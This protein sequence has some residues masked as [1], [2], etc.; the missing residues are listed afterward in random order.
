MTKRRPI[1]LAVLAVMVALA[2]GIG[3]FRFEVNPASV[4]GPLEKAL[5]R[6][7]GYRVAALGGAAFTAFPWPVL[8]LSGLELVKGGASAETASIPL[9][10]ARINV[11]SWLAGDPRISALA[12]FEP[13]ISLVSAENMEE[14]EAVGAV[15][16]NFLRQDRRP[17]LTQLR[18][19]SGEVS[20]DG[21]RWLAGLAIN[22]S[23]VAGNDVRLDAAGD[24]RG[25]PLRLDAVVSPAPV[26][27]FRPIIWKLSVGDLN[28]AFTGM[29]TSPPALEADGQL[30]VT[31]GAGALRSRP[32][33]LSRA[34]TDMLDGLTI[35]GSGRIALPAVQLRQAVIRRGTHSFTGGL[36][37]N[38]M[39]AQPRIAATLHAETLDLTDAMGTFLEGDP[40]ES[41]LA[42]LSG[43]A[44]LQAAAVDMRLS[45]A[46]LDIGALRLENAALSVKFGGSR[47]EA[48]LSHADISGGS[49]KARLSAAIV[50]PELELKCTG[51]VEQVDLGAVLRRAGSAAL[52]GILTGHWTVDATGQRAEDLVRNAGGRA[53]VALRNGE[54]VGLDVERFLRRTEL[55]AAPLPDGRSRFQQVDMGFALKSGVATLID[56]HVKGPQ[57]LAKVQGSASIAARSLDILARLSFEGAGTAQPREERAIRI[58]GPWARPEATPAGIPASGRS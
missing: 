29:L 5:S 9:V 38:L 31:L 41:W 43:S 46:R 27:A 40:V 1:L 58:F 23:N 33:S 19:Q 48:T 37:M 53:L 55:P 15:I 35:A 28:A 34:T 16:R 39:P 25:Q 13:K 44:P 10:K 8:Q 54:G 24:Y 36:D 2:V 26:A 45:V 18:V 14:T 17:A 4:R 32:L 3:S 49:A 12:L 6:D 21:G 42:A 51:Q 7:V 30:S 52:S 11:F 57:W 22:V 50:G 20:L 47:L 56:A